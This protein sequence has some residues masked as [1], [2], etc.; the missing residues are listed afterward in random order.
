MPFKPMP[1]THHCA[2]CHRALWSNW[3]Y[4]LCKECGKKPCKHGKK[5]GECNDCDVEGDRTYDAN[6]GN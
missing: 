5:H 2:D 4:A 1:P 6:K 3:P